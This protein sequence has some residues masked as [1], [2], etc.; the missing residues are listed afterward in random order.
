MTEP[1]R[2]EAEEGKTLAEKFRR[3]G[4]LG[5][6]AQQAL[7]EAIDR[8]IAKLRE[9]RRILADGDGEPAD[10]RSSAPATAKRAGRPKGAKRQLSPEARARIAAA[11]KKRWGKNAESAAQKDA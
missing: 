6:M 10:A 3:C 4:T 11:Q 8:E 2:S 1:S 7:V 5:R 9:V